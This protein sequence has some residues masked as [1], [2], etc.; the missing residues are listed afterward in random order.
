VACWPTTRRGS[1]LLGAILLVCLVARLGWMLHLRDVEPAITT[2]SDTPSYVEPAK[3]LLEDRR[4]TEGPGDPDPVFFRTPGYP[5]FIASVFAATDDNE[6]AVLTVQVLLSVATAWFAFVVAGAL[7]GQA[8]G[9]LAALVNALDA[10][11]FRASGTLL[12]ETLAALVLLAFV[13]IGYRISSRRPPLVPWAFL[14]GLTLALA[15]LIR[16]TTYYL[17]LLVVVVIVVGF[18][19]A[20]VRSWLAVVAAFLVPVV[21]LVGG[22]QVRNKRELDTFR[23]SAVDANNMYVYRAAGVL[24]IVHGTSLAEGQRRMAREF[25]VD[26]GQ[27]L[28]RYY[29]ELFDTGLDVFLDHPVAAAR[30]TADGVGKVTVGVGEATI[31]RYLRVDESRLLTAVLALQ[32][33]AF[34]LA[35]VFGIVVALARDRRRL[36]GHAIALVTV[37]YV[38]LASAGPEAYSRFR[39]P[40]APILSLFA[41]LGIARAAQ[42]FAA[43]TGRRL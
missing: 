30:L 19:R 29:D 3:A 33:L 17:P 40:I 38:C 41:G 31:A 18:W 27:D 21:L 25:P 16:P 5:I 8:A 13:A 15:T 24:S 11:Q 26:D 43:R 39:V 20:G 14:L 7:W 28:G 36:L 6:T 32:V 10:A 42:W 4:F 22:W 34:W 1:L 35:T 23:F 2:S 37:A 12:T 9:I